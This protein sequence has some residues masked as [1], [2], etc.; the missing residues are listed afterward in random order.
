MIITKDSTVESKEL[1]KIYNIGTDIIFPRTG[2][3][4]RFLNDKKYLNEYSRMYLTLN[5]HERSNYLYHNTISY[6]I[7]LAIDNVTFF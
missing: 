7:M 2:S 1:S 6:Q 5:I 4:M 3:R